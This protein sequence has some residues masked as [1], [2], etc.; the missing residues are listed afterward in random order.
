MAALSALGTITVEKRTVFGNKRVV[1]GTIVMGDSSGT[2]PSGGL[3]LSPSQI[4]LK[5]IE[6]MQIEPKEMCYFYNKTTGKIDAYVAAA[7]PGAA[8]VH[9]AANGAV[10]TT[11]AVRFMAIGYGG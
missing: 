1:I 3:A 10:P 7:T 2:W 8:V 9:V 4:G 11:T 5:A 6:W